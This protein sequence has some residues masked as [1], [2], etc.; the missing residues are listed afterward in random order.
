[1]FARYAKD[2]LEK[3]IYPEIRRTPGGA[4]EPPYDVT[5]WSLGLLLGVQVDFAKT[6]APARLKADR[7]R[8]RPRIAGRVS[9]S[10][11]RFGFPYTGPETAMAINRLLAQNARIELLA[12]S[13]V[14]VTGVGR[15]RLD[16]V[17]REFGLQVEASQERGTAAPGGS[18]PR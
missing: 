13:R 11:S 1:M 12:P 4:A 6:P 8:E 3:Q 18:M 2:L 5:A 16:A 17:A 9:G 10:G 15:D 14:V 7:V